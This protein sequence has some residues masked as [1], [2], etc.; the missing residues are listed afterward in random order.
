MLGSGAVFL[1]WSCWVLLLRWKLSCCCYYQPLL[2]LMLPTWFRV[3]LCQ[4]DLGFAMDK[5]QWVL[6]WR[7]HC[8]LTALFR[9]VKQVEQ[10]R[11]LFWHMV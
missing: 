3:V 8:T 6:W 11:K 9:V 4:A 5:E 2:G 10:T 1:H 7:A